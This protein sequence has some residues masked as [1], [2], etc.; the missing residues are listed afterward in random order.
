MSDSTWFIA[1]SDVNDEA[2]QHN[3]VCP[4]HLLSTPP[5]TCTPLANLCRYFSS[6]KVQTWYYVILTEVRTMHF[7]K[8]TALH[9]DKGMGLADAQWTTVL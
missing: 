4:V 9:I 7:I 3:D 5:S 1:H 2:S 6:S 8:C